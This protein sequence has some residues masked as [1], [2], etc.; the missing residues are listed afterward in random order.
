MAQ[1]WCFNIASLKFSQKQNID[2][3]KMDPIQSS[4]MGPY[5]VVTVS[6]EPL[7]SARILIFWL[8]WDISFFK[9]YFGLLCHY[10]IGQLK[11]WAGNEG[12][13]EEMT[14]SKGPQGG[15]EPAAAAA[16]T[17]PLYMGRLL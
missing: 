12:K 4:F 2:L 17:Q 8:G 14:C 11:S 13:R 5:M 1:T 7:P 9:R 16:R 3:S 10:L 15:I 6:P